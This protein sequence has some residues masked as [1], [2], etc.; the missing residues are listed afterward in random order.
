MVWL[1]I[2]LFLD[3]WQL[4]TSYPYVADWGSLVLPGFLFSTCRI[5]R[6]N[7]LLYYTLGSV[8]YVSFLSAQV[9]LTAILGVT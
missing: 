1:L 7:V 4:V 6:P 3:V 5:P 8:L 9:G 2:F